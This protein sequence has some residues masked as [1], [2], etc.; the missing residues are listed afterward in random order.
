MA[1][2]GYGVNAAVLSAP[3]RYPR[4]ACAGAPSGCGPRRRAPEEL[5][6]HRTVPTSPSPRRRLLRRGAVPVSATAAL[7]LLAGSATSAGAVPSEATGTAREGAPGPRP[8]VP[9]P[10]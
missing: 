3:S 7:A 6:V 10:P 1:S 8:P 2:P 4:G 9:P 5:L